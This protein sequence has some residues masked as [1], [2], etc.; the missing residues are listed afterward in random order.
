MKKVKKSKVE[1]FLKLNPEFRYGLPGY[2][3]VQDG[4]GILIIAPKEGS[5]EFRR[6]KAI[7]EKLLT[8][9]EIRN[10]VESLNELKKEF[11]KKR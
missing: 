3:F 10:L 7:E 2:S 8:D 9:P 4:N 6:R 1:K 11:F 5:A